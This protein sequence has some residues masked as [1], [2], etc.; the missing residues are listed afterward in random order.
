MEPGWE[1]LTRRELRLKL[2]GP[3]T[4]APGET[5]M[6]ETIAELRVKAAIQNSTA[7]TP[8]AKATVQAT[9]RNSSAD[10]TLRCF[11]PEDQTAAR[12]LILEGLGEHFGFID[13]S[14]NPDVDDIS[15]TYLA[16]GHLF[17]VVVSD[18]TL[19]GTGGLVFLDQHVAQIVRVSV[20]KAYRRRGIG[21]AIVA[22]LV[23]AARGRGIR[24]I[25][26]ETNK[27]WDSAIGLYLC[28]GFI[29]YRRD[30]TSVYLALILDQ[31][32]SSTR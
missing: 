22:E 19:V 7:C 32:L 29:E 1:W 12:R 13:E 3:T 4:I 14:L 6:D 25:E 24:R 17:L 26:V 23:G 16:P 11:M 5:L 18:T 27:D 30:E 2:L 21:R 10:I 28:L 9:P 31:G 15:A 8:L 20:S